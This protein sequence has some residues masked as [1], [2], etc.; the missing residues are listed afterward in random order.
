MHHKTAKA[1]FFVAPC[2]FFRARAYAR[3]SAC[4]RAY[5]IRATICPSAPARG[6]AG[7]YPRRAQVVHLS[8]IKE[9]KKQK[10]KMLRKSATCSLFNILC[11]VATLR[12]I[13]FVIKRT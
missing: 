6:F 11:T 7:D 8:G 13:V 12:L 3:A 4:L 1:V 5:T 9:K 10:K 2:L